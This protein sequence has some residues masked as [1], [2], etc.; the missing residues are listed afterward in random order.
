MIDE[1]TPK[2][3]LVRALQTLTIQVGLP[4]PELE[5]MFHTSRQWRFDLAWP[6]EKIA[7]ECDG[8]VFS[9]GR[10][11]RGV[12]Y[13]EDC[14]KINEAILLGWRVFRVTDRLI[15][16][17]LAVKWLERAFGRTVEDPMTNVRKRKKR[18]VIPFAPGA[19][20]A[21]ARPGLGLPDIGMVIEDSGDKRVMVEIFSQRTQSKVVLPIDRSRLKAA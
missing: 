20:V 17:G 15:K 13:E 10:H 11:T 8:G 16:S 9:G 5:Y 3:E 19:R 4:R 1:T 2:S 18:P 12:G 21:V 14:R 7:F 6:D